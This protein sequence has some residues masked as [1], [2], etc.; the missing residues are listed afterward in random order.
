MLVYL[1]EYQSVGGKGF[2]LSRFPLYLLTF[3]VLLQEVYSRSILINQRVFLYIQ[4]ELCSQPGRYGT[5][6][7]LSTNATTNHIPSQAT[8]PIDPASEGGVLRLLSHS[9]SPVRNIGAIAPNTTPTNQAI[10]NNSNI[11]VQPNLVDA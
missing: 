2:F 8:P 11:H 9:S 4:Q 5:Q 6:T 7:G 10:G 3:F 1:S